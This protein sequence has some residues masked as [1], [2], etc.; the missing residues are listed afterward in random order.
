M[1]EST[2]GEYTHKYDGMPIKTPH[3]EYGSAKDHL[4]CHNSE[5]F[6]KRGKK[7]RVI[8]EMAMH[9]LFWLNHSQNTEL[10]FGKR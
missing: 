9:T 10:F 5:V 2:Y 6:K 7:I 1:D 3:P 4:D 8:Y